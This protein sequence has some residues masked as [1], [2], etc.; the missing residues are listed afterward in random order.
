MEKLGFSYQR[1]LK[2]K[3]V[4][5]KRKGVSDWWLLTRP[6]EWQYKPA[7]HLYSQRFGRSSSFGFSEE[8]KFVIQDGNAFDFKSSNYTKKDYYFYLA[9]FCSSTFDRLLSIYSKRIMK[10]YDLGKAQIKNI[11]IVDVCNNHIR[12]TE[13][14]YQMVDIGVR[15]T[16]GES[17]LRYKADSLVKTFYPDEEKIY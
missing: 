10:G 4:L 11:P 2:F 1:L 17:Y 9:L 7:F 3:D 8:K 5:E 16:E 15:L 6:R 12:E 13:I 14:Y